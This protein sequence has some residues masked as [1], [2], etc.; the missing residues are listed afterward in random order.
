VRPADQFHVGIVVDEFGATLA[1]LTDAF[2]CEWGDE[3]GGLTA[4]QLP[5]GEVRVDF[6]CVYSR[7]T[8]RLEII[9]SIPGTLWMPVADSG[10]HHLGYWS[11]DVVADSARLTREGF[12]VEA[13]GAQP[14]GSPYWAYHRADHGPRIEIISRALEPTLEQFWSHGAS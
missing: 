6:H 8:P 11:D 5:T 7:T 3:L 9:R 2:G 10:I 1:Q 12:K 4:V 13:I 14:D